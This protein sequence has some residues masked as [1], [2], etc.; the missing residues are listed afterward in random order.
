[1]EESLSFKHINGLKKRLNPEEINPNDKKVN[2]KHFFVSDDVSHV[3]KLVE[4][5]VV[6][7]SLESQLKSSQLKTPSVKKQY[8]FVIP[9]IIIL[10]NDTNKDNDD[11]F[12]QCLLN[13]RIPNFRGVSK[14]VR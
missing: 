14:N 11:L 10:I 5:H 12:L 8:M 1:V 3:R 9:V 2:I 13:Q 4:I 7:S 6:L